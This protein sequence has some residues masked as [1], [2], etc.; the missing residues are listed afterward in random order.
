MGNLLSTLNVNGFK[1]AFIPY[2]ISANNLWPGL[3]EMLEIFLT[4][5]INS[6]LGI[7]DFK[8]YF[9]KGSVWAFGLSVLLLTFV[10]GTFLTIGFTEPAVFLLYIDL[11]NLLLESYSTTPP[12][13]PRTSTRW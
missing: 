1:L 3:S 11:P 7:D 12:F 9:F 6:L 2:N 5:S 13:P 8:P 10:E 4:D